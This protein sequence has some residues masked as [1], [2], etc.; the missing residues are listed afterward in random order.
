M[1]P[2]FALSVVAP[3]KTRNISCS[4]LSKVLLRGAESKR[5]SE[6]QRKLLE[7]REGNTEVKGKLVAGELRNQKDSGRTW[8]SGGRNVKHGR[9]GRLKGNPP[10]HGRRKK[11]GWF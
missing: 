6:N 2:F 9:L 1:I 10:E 4:I 11:L 7:H 8:E 5:F 3:W